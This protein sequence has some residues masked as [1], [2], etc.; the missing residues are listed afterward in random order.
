MAQ[1][2]GTGHAAKAGIVA[3]G[4]RTPTPPRGG[5]RRPHAQEENMVSNLELREKYSSVQ[6]YEEDFM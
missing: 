2:C 1:A 3:H 6:D 4:A 5:P